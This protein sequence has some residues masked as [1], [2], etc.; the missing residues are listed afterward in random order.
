MARVPPLKRRDLGSMPRRPTKQWP[1]SNW[2]SNAAVYGVRGVR[3]P[4]GSPNYGLYASGDAIGLSPLA[5]G[6]DTRTV[7]HLSQ[8]CPRLI[9]GPGEEDGTRRKPTS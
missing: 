2:W 4:Y 5:G 9:R 8:L 6:I 1:V 7:Y 3:F